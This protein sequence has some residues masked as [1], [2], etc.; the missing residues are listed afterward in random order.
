MGP[1]FEAQM[2]KRGSQAVK[3]IAA[4]V[5]GWLLVL[6][7][8]A[9]LVLPGPGLLALFAGM[10][11]LATQYSWAERRLE[12]VKKAALRAAADSVASTPRIV[13]S[14]LGILVLA[15]VG[16]VWGLHP[17][18]PGWWPIEE[19]W[20]LAGGWGT[21]TTLIGSAVIAAAMV[22]YSYFNFRETRDEEPAD[23]AGPTTAR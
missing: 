7:G 3:G 15:A 4:Q 17:D 6:I 9:A 5:A 22:V 21:G 18:A 13:M 16:V 10:A 20:W 2:V 1:E 12:P 11:L 8:I 23:R 19:R 14:V